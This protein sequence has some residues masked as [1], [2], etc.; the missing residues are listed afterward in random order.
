MKPEIAIIVA[1]AADNGIGCSDGLPW[2]MPE[3]LKYFKQRTLGKPVIMGRKTFLSLGDGKVG[4]PLK[5][6]A[7]IVLTNNGFFQ[8]D[9]HIKNSLD[10]GI[11]LAIEIAKKDGQDEI[12]IIGGANIFKQA[13]KKADVIYLTQINHRDFPETN[14]F[15]PK[16]YFE[17]WKVVAQTNRSLHENKLN[18]DI[19]CEFVELRKVN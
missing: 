18:I 14:T 4:K 15:L 8:E 13:I 12:M 9:I 2:H 1:K 3:E 6:R 16:E 11:E 17:G 7:N 19:E 10:E 5:G